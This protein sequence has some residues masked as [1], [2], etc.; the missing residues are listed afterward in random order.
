M[1]KF[2][3]PLILIMLW[4]TYLPSTYAQS[5]LG[6]LSVEKIMRDPSWIGSSPTGINWSEDSKTVYFNWNPENNPSDS[7]YKITL[8]NTTPQKVSK[9][10]RDA[11]PPRFTV[12]NKDDSKRLINE[13]GNLHILDVKTG[14]RKNLI[15][16]LDRVTNASFSADGTKVFYQMNGNLFRLHLSSGELTQLTD[17]RQGNEQRGR[18]EPRLSEQEEWLQQ[19][20]LAW[21]EVLKER[22]ERRD[23][24]AEARRSLNNDD[25]TGPI[26]LYSGSGGFNNIGI[27]PDERFVTYGIFEFS[28]DSKR[29]G[30]PTYV[31]E[32]GFTETLN[33][34]TKVG[35]EQGSSKMFIYDTQ[36]NESYELKISD[37][38]G[39]NDKPDYWNEYPEN[40]DKEYERSVAPS[41][42]FWS[43]DGKYAVVQ[44][45]SSDNK[46]RWIM[47]LDPETGG[48]KLLDRQRDEAWIGGP[49]TGG[50]GGGS[51]GWMP[52][53]KRFWFQ[54]EE[55]GYSHL[56]TVDVTTGAKK[57]L[58]SG[59][60]EVYDPEISKDKKSWYFTSNEVHP[61][62]RHFY[63]MPI[64]GGN[65]EKITTLTGQS[66][67]S[68]SPDE[69]HLAIRYSY[70][71]K[72]WELYLMENKAGA[73]PKQITNSLTEEFMSY[74]WMDPE[75]VTFKARDGADVYAR[76][77][78]PRTGTSNG[79]PA[80]IFV[81]GAGYLQN[82]HKGW[83]SYFREYMFHN[84][85]AEQGYTVLD[86]DYRA[87]AGYGRDWRTAI[88]RH[89]GGWDLNDNTDGAKYLVAEH[90]VDPDKIGLYGGSYGG[91]IT[92]MAM[93]NE[94]EVFSAGAALRSVTDWAHYNHGYTANILNTPTQ[95]SLA[96]ARSS[97]IYF[98]EGLQG[99]L[100]IAH[101]MVDTN[102]HFQ[103]VV[104]LA[105]RLIELEKD[106]W[107]MAVYPLEDHGFVEPSSWT[108]EYKRIKKLFDE[109]LKG[110]K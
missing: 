97:P 51:I 105:Q 60:F 56:Y 57:A 73:T 54:S 27:S 9:A 72:P 94:P 22:K 75:V 38:P 103:D 46:D 83:S 17:F 65:R 101:G 49:G 55:S 12:S 44:F 20:Q 19:D 14:V 37:I 61:G 16:T 34:R 98:A 31:T 6:T 88:Y 4:M 74:D 18:P 71:N 39:L 26:A 53:N 63:R 110:L 8:T 3:L 100:L 23:L 86:I 1:R 43:E 40:A 92:L 66:E 64:E 104:R 62:E 15:N 30:V 81:H 28:M 95:D 59:N 41:G 109:N 36:K 89:M 45:R 2:R 5:Q 102:V 99:P 35:T 96:Y 13:G 21:I 108:D 82:A 106:N 48:L 25:S 33:A 76:L 68:M 85:L 107:E 24:V 58:T 87:S 29:T 67:V 10:E 70:S 32:S 11:L 91:F 52:D 84:L 42:P 78:K 79:G 90:G 47:L 7:L 50:F 93:F 77:Y 69:K 80:V